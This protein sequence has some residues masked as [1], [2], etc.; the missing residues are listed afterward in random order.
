MGQTK[1]QVLVTTYANGADGHPCTMTT[2]VIPFDDLEAACR[3]ADKIN[4]GRREGVQQ[5]ALLLDCEPRRS[6]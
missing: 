6:Q 3:A 2:V 1:A 5:R 4:E